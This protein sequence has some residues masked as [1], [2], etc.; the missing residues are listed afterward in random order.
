MA[1]NYPNGLMTSRI[2]DIRPKDTAFSELSLS[3]PHFLSE[4]RLRPSQTKETRNASVSFDNENP[5][6]FSSDLQSRTYDAMSQAETPG[7]PPVKHEK[8]SYLSNLEDRPRSIPSSRQSR[9]EFDSEWL[10]AVN[11]KTTETRMRREHSA[12]SSMMSS[13]TYSPKPSFGQDELSDVV[14]QAAA[15][16]VTAKHIAVRDS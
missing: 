10:R 14:L 13:V 16:K 15:V 12:L 7:K 3:S 8:D 6:S 2:N 5:V 4:D 9:T 11:L 1:Y